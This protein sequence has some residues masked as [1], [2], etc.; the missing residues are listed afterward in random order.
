MSV[1]LRTFNRRKAARLSNLAKSSLKGAGIYS[2][3]S[4]SKRSRTRLR[5]PAVEI[6]PSGA[7]SS[8]SS[9]D[10]A[11][12]VANLGP[13]LRLDPTLAHI[14]GAFEPSDS[15]PAISAISHAPAFLPAIT[16]LII[17]L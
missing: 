15:T 2:P 12:P 11:A 14:A 7:T 10:S 1:A 9:L 5:S 16:T 8:S 17:K 4:I 6:S 3:K 13:V